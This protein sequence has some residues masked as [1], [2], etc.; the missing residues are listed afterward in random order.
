[1]K[2]QD[3]ELIEFKKYKKETLI[4]VNIVLPSDDALTLE[5]W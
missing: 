4:S 3:M 1:M 5:D 2:K